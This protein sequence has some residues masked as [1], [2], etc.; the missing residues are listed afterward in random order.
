MRVSAG[1]AE[2]KKLLFFVMAARLAC[3]KIA[4]NSIYGVM[5]VGML[6]QRCFVR[7]VSMISRLIP[8]PAKSTLPKLMIYIYAMAL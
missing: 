5:A 8:I 4:A 7:P 3:V 6:T 1:F 2:R